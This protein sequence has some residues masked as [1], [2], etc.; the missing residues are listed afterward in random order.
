M[1][2]ERHSIVRQ[3]LSDVTV[4]E[5]A[6]GVAGDYAG[7]VL[8][9][10]GADLIKLERPGG[11]IV[12]RGAGAFAYLNLN[13]R[14]ATADPGSPEGRG[15]FWRM[16]QC[17]DLVIE[18]RGAGCLWDWCTDWEEVTARYPSMVVASISGFGASGPY[19]GYEWSDLVAQAFSGSLV[20]MGPDLPPVRLPA[21]IE[22]CAVGH[23]A[24]VGALA[25]VE[26]ARATGLG[27]FVDCAAY[28]ALG[29]NPNRILRHLGFEYN[30]RTPPD[31]ALSGVS[32]GTG[33]LLP[34]GIFPCADGYVSMM[35][36][37]QNL[38]RMFDVIGDESLR[39][40]FA[41]PGAFVDPETKER[42]DA[43]LYPWLLQRTRSEV[44]AEAQAVGWPVTSVNLIEEIL[45]V[46]HHHQ[47]G[48]WTQV[49]DPS[50]GR[51][52][53]P[54]PLSRHGEGGWQQRRRAPTLGEHNKEIEREL[55]DLHN[56][57]SDQPTFTSQKHRDPAQ[58]PL[59]G[60][61]VLDL[62]TVWSGPYV[63]LLLAD[64]GAEVIRLESPWVFPPSAKGFEARPKTEMILGSIMNTYGPPVPGRPDRP[65][66]RHAMN[67][68]V[69][70]GKLSCSLDTR[71][72]EARELFLRLVEKSDVV[73]E[74]L[75]LSALHQMGIWESEVL[76]R[77]PQVLMVRLP[78]A[79]LSGDWAG[80]IG[81][82][83]QFDALSGLASL[84]GPSASE[85]AESPSTFHM[86]TVTGPAGALAIL[87]G[88]HYRAA[89]G[90]GQMIELSQTDNLL[91]QLGDV[92]A[93]YQLGLVPE[94]IGNRD[95]RHAPQGLYPCAGDH[96][97]AL[98]V[99]HDAD[100]VALCSAIGQPELA[101]Q[102]RFATESARHA[103]HD[104]LDLIISA[105][106]TPRG[107]YDAFQ[108]LQEAGVPAAPVMDDAMTVSDPHVRGRDW[109][110]PLASRDVGTFPHI[111]PVF[112]GF[113]LAW[114]RGAPVL[115]EHNEYVFKELLG[116][117]DSE[118]ER[119]VAERIAVE[120]YLDPDGNP[121]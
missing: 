21:S 92:F 3:L 117:T 43:A 6:E 93:S 116:V 46:D 99:R 114:E 83:A 97:V 118:Y 112:R 68:S 1:W 20:S 77:N 14:G 57:G 54:G 34:L 2:G 111:G 107:C 119:L 69:G 86:D 27:A 98:T 88:L 32:T 49:D 108:R 115:G 18:T 15:I 16:L 33:T 105:W 13:K 94:R 22:L 106:T 71:T 82:G 75:K 42:L 67:N 96:W 63:T 120:D 31:K 47:R 11:D 110:R 10:L 45:E 79:G 103:S 50:A 101:T 39:A 62:T 70:R 80:Y 78:P 85:I 23:T 28:E 52:R 113:P 104:E 41:R 56:P 5:L 90:R 9:D 7:K 8:A 26:R 17:A 35:T 38:P 121:L 25:A 100:W 102:E 91:H 61:R 81:F 66:N 59:R 58:P 30:G 87:A 65:Y 4:L 76:H 89:S 73:I 109:L 19:A 40:A 53:L 37:L 74:N 12:R 72:P 36:T 29:G 95:Q 64:L 44:M 51:L 60:V 24:A 84:V 55:S 48:F